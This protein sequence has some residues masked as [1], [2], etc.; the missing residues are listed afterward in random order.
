MVSE[1]HILALNH[2]L[3]SRPYEA[4]RAK[5]LSMRSLSK[6]TIQLVSLGE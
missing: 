3:L 4:L 5:F 2:H 1:V 6:P